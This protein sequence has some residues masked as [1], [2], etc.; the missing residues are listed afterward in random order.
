V[1]DM[2]NVTPCHCSADFS[3]GKMRIRTNG[4]KR[5]ST[6]KGLFAKY[7]DKIALRFGSDLFTAISAKPQAEQRSVEDCAIEPRAKMA[8]R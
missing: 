5:F 1:R 7:M 4:R 2:H 8:R 3:K 6:S